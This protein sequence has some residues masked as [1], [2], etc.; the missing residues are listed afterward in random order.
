MG[1]AFFPLDKNLYLRCCLSPPRSFTLSSELTKRVRFPR[2]AGFDHLHHRCLSALPVGEM[3]LNYLWHGKGPFWIDFRTEVFVHWIKQRETILNTKP[4]ETASRLMAFDLE[5]RRARR[6]LI[7]VPQFLL[8][9]LVFTLL[10][11]PRMWLAFAEILSYLCCK[12][13]NLLEF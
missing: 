3:G 8:Q 5:T 9:F 6:P 13:A 10:L 7:S 11:K 4:M 12:I 2:R 1:W